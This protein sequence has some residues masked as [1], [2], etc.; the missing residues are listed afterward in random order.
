VLPVVGVTLVCCLIA[1]RWAV[2][3][4]N[5]ESVLFRE[6]ERL[7]LGLWLQHLRRDRGYTPS[8]SEAL[9]CGAVI[10]LIRFFMSMSAELP[11]TFDGFAVQQI[12]FLIAVCL[13]PTL[14]MTAILT[15]SPQSSPDLAAAYAPAVDDS[16][17]GVACGRNPSSSKVAKHSDTVPLSSRS[18]TAEGAGRRD[19]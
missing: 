2:D 19:E 5:K 4:F 8:V 6:S 10:L 1:V 3:Q 16:S 11:D 7:D 14:I 13:G 9:F 15:R 18:G 12:V 17:S